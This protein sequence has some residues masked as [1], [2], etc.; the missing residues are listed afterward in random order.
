MLIKKP[1]TAQTR[2]MDDFCRYLLLLEPKKNISYYHRFN[3]PILFSTIP[4]SKQTKLPFLPNP[5]PCR[6][7]L[8]ESMVTKVSDRFMES[9]WETHYVAAT[10]KLAG[11]RRQDFSRR[12]KT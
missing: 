7:D 2:L 4:K 8:Y 1:P 5:P 11:E 3:V 6:G 12:K 9:Q 10:F